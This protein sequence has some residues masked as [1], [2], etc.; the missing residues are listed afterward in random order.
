MGVR[1]TPSGNFELRITHRLLP[2]PVYLTFNNED[3]ANAYGTQARELLDSGVVPAGLV[4]EKKAPT[5]TL[6]SVIRAWQAHGQLS[7]AD[8]E[9]LNVLTGEIGS[10]KMSGLTYAWCEQWVR[11]MKLKANLAPGTIRKRIGALA[12]CIDWELRKTPDLLVGN[13][14][15]SLP[16]G[17]ASYSAKD[18]ADA[19]KLGKRARSDKVRDRRLRKGELEQI[20]DALAGKKRPDRQRALEPDEDLRDLFLLI[21]HTGLRLREAYTIQSEWLGE[22]SLR[23]KSSK[24]WHGREAWRDVPMVKEIRPMM[25]RR[26]AKSKPGAL[27]FPW[28]DQDPE[29]LDTVTTRLSRRFG[30]LFGYAG[31][32]DLTE[33]DLRHEATCRW[34]EM[35][36]KRG[37]WLFREAEIEKI[38]GWAPGSSMA[39]RYASFRADDLAGRLD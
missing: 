28:W 19:K 23:V 22:R 9:I 4:D 15:R 18:A 8:D 11:D 35:R 16:R 27:I 26:A 17:S 20:M 21:L 34:Y 2:K 3:A 38:M 30:L 37:N 36:D 6:H 31:C 24:Q 1:Q 29:T 33:H 12:R 32:E 39:K 13:P 25:A 14:L 5:Q 7:T 10:L